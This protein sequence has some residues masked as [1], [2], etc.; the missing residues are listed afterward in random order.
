ME[1]Q[2]TSDK[3]AKEAMN[4]SEQAAKEAINRQA[5]FENTLSRQLS[6][7]LD[8]LSQQQEGLNQ[9]NA[10]IQGLVTTFIDQTNKQLSSMDGVPQS[11]L[12]GTEEPIGSDSILS[13]LEALKGEEYTQQTNTPSNDSHQYSIQAPFPLRYTPIQ[14]V[15][16]T[17]APMMFQ[18]PRRHHAFRGP[19]QPCRQPD[20]LF[21]SM[22]PKGNSTHYSGRWLLNPANRRVWI[23]YP[24]PLDAA[25]LP[26]NVP[27][28]PAHWINR[29]FPDG[30]FLL[31]NGEWVLPGPN[32]RTYNY[33]MPHGHVH[34]PVTTGYT[35]TTAYTT[36]GQLTTL[37]GEEPPVRNPIFTP[38]PVNSNDMA[39]PKEKPS[40]FSGFHGHGLEK[41]NP[42][43][44][45][46]PGDPGG[47]G[48]HGSN[49]S[50]FGIGNEGNT[51]NWRHNY[52]GPPD[53]PGDPDGNGGPPDPGR[54][55][56]GGG[57]DPD[58]KGRY[59]HAKPDAGAYPTLNNNKTFD[60]WYEAVITTARAQDMFK[61]FDTEYTPKN[62]AAC[63][64]L[65]RMNAW[66]FAVLQ[67]IVKTSNGK[68]I[69]KSHF[70]DCNCYDIIVKLIA[71]AH[72]SV[73]G[74]LESVDTLNWLT[75]TRYATS[76]GSA[77]EFIIK[78]DETVT[79]YNDAQAMART[80]SATVCRSYSSRMHLHL[81]ES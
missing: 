71:D 25:E 42:S 64:E 61:I 4:R 15:S 14:P 80:S 37:P 22:L 76:K 52:P 26:A 65:K 19:Q 77:V 44:A 55:G 8:Q 54:D 40:L 68:V 6:T 66:F 67:K 38:H 12:S 60:S 23:Q 5:T 9:S 53:D 11:L 1:L 24:T 13:Q 30:C 17:S 79:K 20:I 33:T 72:V 7:Y 75:S 51:P 27:N 3:A 59:F 47:S 35:P 10:S 81:S 63:D 62:K 2:A 74:T 29:R 36:P 78:F 50:D 69:V 34:T 28:D 48:Y 41:P 21:P 49:H 31:P 46:D 32:D 56:G 73:A 16:S 18:F 45:G 57:D 39:S 43:K 70:H 58:P